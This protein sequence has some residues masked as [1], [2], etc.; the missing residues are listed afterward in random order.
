MTTYL[1][2]PGYVISR[3]D[4]QRHRIGVRDL[5]KLYGLKKGQYI[6][7]MAGVRNKMPILSPREDGN[8]C[9]KRCGLP[10]PTNMRHR[11][12]DDLGVLGYEY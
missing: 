6:T 3:H 7:S 9:C 2:V 10:N 4:K 11:C 5:V 1:V 8:Y 12:D